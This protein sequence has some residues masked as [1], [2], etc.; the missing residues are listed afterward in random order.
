MK[1]ILGH[2]LAGLALV[3]GGVAL[4]VAC[5]HD[6]SSLFVQ[7]VI[8]P[9]PVTAG[10]S[11]TFNNDPS[12]EIL[13]IG[14]LDIA[15]AQQYVPV[16]LVGNQLVAE[17]NSQQLQ[18]ETSTI[19]IQGAVVTITD[20]AGNQLNSFTSPTS[21][22]VYPSTGTVPGYAV[23]DIVLIDQATV[24]AV[25]ASKGGELTG[26]GTTTLLTY[27]KFFGHT[28]GGDYVES[29]NF[30]FPVT[31]C[32]GCLVTFSSADDDP[33]PELK[34]PNC[35]GNASAG[36][37]TASSL[38]VPCTLGQDTTIDCTDC[39]GNPVCLGAYKN[40]GEPILDAGG[41]G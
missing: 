16:F 37:S 35:L 27:A 14:T 31:V 5:Q 33:S 32:E 18:T 15:F 10:Q 40:G 26:G 3:G 34:Q 12:Q 9:T 25:E 4:T 22:T 39:Q 23:V 24:K 7:N 41:G 2:C 11:C 6:D 20:S 8:Y 30:Q 36:A 29:N 28:L 1:R 38:P 13:P 21:G 19:N 17:S